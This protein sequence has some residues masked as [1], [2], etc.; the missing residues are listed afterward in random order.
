[1]LVGEISAF[2]TGGISPAAQ[3]SKTPDGVRQQIIA[4]TAQDLFPLR[5]RLLPVIQPAS[6]GGH[7]G[8]VTGTLSG[9]TQVMHS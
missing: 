1:M 8:T 9:V 6:R 2:H 3:L 5:K 4:L 7:E